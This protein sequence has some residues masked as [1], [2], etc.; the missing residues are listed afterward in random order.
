M[1]QCALKY[2]H[3]LTKSHTAPAGTYTMHYI[4]LKPQ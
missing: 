1:L 3:L 4:C 2:A